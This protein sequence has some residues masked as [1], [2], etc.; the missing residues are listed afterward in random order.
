MFLASMLHLDSHIRMHG[1]STP[2][3][4]VRDTPLGFI[5][6]DTEDRTRTFIPAGET[7]T[8][9]TEVFHSRAWP[10]QLDIRLPPSVPSSKVRAFVQDLDELLLFQ[11]TR[12]SAAT[13]T[14]ID[15]NPDL[16]SFTTRTSSLGGGTPAPR[17]RAS[18]AKRR[19][20]FDLATQ[21][22]NR[23]FERARGHESYIAVLDSKRWVIRFHTFVKEE[24]KTRFRQTRAWVSAFFKMAL[25]L[26]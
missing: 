14:S 9:T 17:G 5:V 6:L 3:G 2:T 20:L 10:L 16:S 13:T 22:E 4:T 26:R 12:P 23:V 24:N 21:E 19:A 11:G 15:G 8:T 25:W 7:I 1:T 18:N